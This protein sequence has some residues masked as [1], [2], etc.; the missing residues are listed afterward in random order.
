MALSIPAGGLK[1]A[2]AILLAGFF[3][4]LAARVSVL[5]GEP[6]GWD[7]FYHERVVSLSIEQGKLLPFDP[8]SAGGRTQTYLPFYYSLII[9]TSFSTGLSPESLLRAASPFLFFLAALSIFIFSGRKVSSLLALAVFASFPEILM[10][11]AASGLPSVASFFPLALLLASFFSEGKGLGFPLALLLSIEVGEFHLLSALVLALFSAANFI[12]RKNQK[13]LFVSIAG[14]AIPF[15]WNKFST[16][17]VPFWGRAPGLAR[18]L[19]PPFPLHLLLPAGIILADLALNWKRKDKLSAAGFLGALI[20]LSFFSPILPSRFVTYL[21]FALALYATTLGS[22]KW[23]VCVSLAALL[24]VSGAGTAGNLGPII[25]SEDSAAI[26]WLDENILDSTVVAGHTD[27]TSVFLLG[28]SMTIIDGYSEGLADAWARQ[29][30]IRQA[31]SSGDFSGLAEKYG[32]KFVYTNKAEHR[33]L[34]ET[35]KLPKN[36]LFDNNYAKILVV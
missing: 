2:L 7:Y 30:A 31:Y 4:L 3:A 33:F 27:L 35:P 6:S 17:T 36:A 16:K 19:D 14:L 29:E 11:A 22:W 21:P 24:A 26:G 8:L 32:A 28:H 18:I 23:P 9:A 25:S 15:A 13:A 20:L 5:S 1:L 12:F 10:F 34:G